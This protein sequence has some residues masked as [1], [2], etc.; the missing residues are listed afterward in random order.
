MFFQYAAQQTSGGNPLISMI[1]PFVIM[2]AV[3]YFLLIRPQKKKQQ[4]RNSMLSALKKGD[5][6][7]TIGGLHGTIMELTDDTVVLRVNDVTKLTFDRSA[8]SHTIKESEG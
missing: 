1:I 6:I 2:I 8:I 5:K 4:Q 7:V 3:F